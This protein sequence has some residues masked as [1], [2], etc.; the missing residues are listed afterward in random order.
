LPAGSSSS[1]SPGLQLTKGDA[2]S[3]IE[4]S[5]GP[6]VRLGESLNQGMALLPLFVTYRPNTEQIVFENWCK[7]YARSAFK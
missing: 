7:I 5:G 6:A 2:N 1:V 4:N 3:R